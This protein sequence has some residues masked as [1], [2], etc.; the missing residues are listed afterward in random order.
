MK[1]DFN[2][3]KNNLKENEKYLSN[4][5]IEIDVPNYKSEFNNIFEET[6]IP[7]QRVL[8]Q[9]PLKNDNNINKTIIPS[10][11]QKINSNSEFTGWNDLNDD[12]GMKKDSTSSVN[13]LLPQ[14]KPTNSKSNI[15]LK[16][17][18]NNQIEDKKLYFKEKPQNLFDDPGLHIKKS[19]ESRKVNIENLLLNKNFD[20]NEN[21]LSIY[22][23][24]G[25]N[26]NNINNTTSKIL[27]KSPILM[28][29]L[30]MKK[31]EEDSKMDLTRLIKTQDGKEH[32]V[33][34]KIEGGGD[35]K[36]R[37]FVMNLILPNEL[38]KLGENE[39]KNS[40][41]GNERLNQLRDKIFNP[42]TEH[43]VYTGK[44]KKALLNMLTAGHIWK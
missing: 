19:R 24:I 21:D 26:G 5:A 34:R 7:V 16:V 12:W 2:N 3:L 13:K 38:A 23:N 39:N 4:N 25:I 40:V 42:P 11:S 9:Q 37:S 31:Q 22:D 29:R 6:I 1:N 36:S 32:N 8:N 28:T 41:T 30:R 33:K 35:D 18:E 14:N 44:N 15:I 17:K 43:A 20:Y 10:T 27:S